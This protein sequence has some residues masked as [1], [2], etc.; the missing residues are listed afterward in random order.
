MTT[1]IVSQPQDSNETTTTIVNTTKADFYVSF[2]K[3]ITNL[4]ALNS[5]GDSIVSA[6]WV[7]GPIAGEEFNIT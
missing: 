4:T 1:S 5:T 6:Y 7:F 2:V 3:P